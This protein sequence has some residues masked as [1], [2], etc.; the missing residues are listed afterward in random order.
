MAKG[1]LRIATCQFAVSGS[2]GRNGRAIRGY[3]EQAKAGGAEL[4]H[5]SE[6]A[7]CGYAGADHE[8]LA[9]F[10][11]ARLRAETEAI[12]ELTGRL[13]LW[14]VLGSM[15]YITEG[16]KPHNCLYLIDPRG[17]IAGR[18]D[19]RFCMER[20]LAHYSPGDHFAVFEINGVRCGLLICYDLRFPEIYRALKRRK[21]ACVI[22][23]FYNA[24]QPGRTVHADI[25]QPTMQCR[26]AT[27]Y[28]WIS[29]ANSSAYYAAYASCFIRPDGKI[30]EKLKLHRAGMMINTVDTDQSFYD[31][32]GPFRV[33]AMR[34][35]LHSGKTIAHTRS[36][37][38]TII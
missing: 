12:R 17:R 15:H 1:R 14:M 34:G 29:M 3:M 2:V 32:S 26:A 21:V 8:S 20:D 16:I 10:D 33:S 19:K 31:A 11:W 7:L 4:V 9:G 25:M 6:C 5:F 24:R 23:S 18:Y 38:R 13:R 36:K 22:Q 27:N 37:R 30:V 28:F 35:T